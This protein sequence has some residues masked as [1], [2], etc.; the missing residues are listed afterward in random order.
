MESDGGTVTEEASLPGVLSVIEKYASIRF[1]FHP[2]SLSNVHLYIIL[3]VLQ[4]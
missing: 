1:P 4:L 2:F 3:A